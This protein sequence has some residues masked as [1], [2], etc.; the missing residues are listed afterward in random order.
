[1]GG[2]GKASVS[3]G[4][5]SCTSTLGTG[6]TSKWAIHFFILVIWS[7]WLFAGAMSSR[8]ASRSRWR[9]SK[10]CGILRALPSRIRLSS[11]TTWG[12]ASAGKVRAECFNVL[13]IVNENLFLSQWT[14]TSRRH[15]SMD[16]GCLE[17]RWHQIPEG[18]ERFRWKDPEEK[19]QTEVELN[20]FRIISSTRTCW[21]MEPLPTIGVAELVERS[22]S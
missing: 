15:L 12:L 14:C 9:S 19:W 17:L 4:L 13:P 11:V 3:S 20:N 8:S 6:T 21:L 22:A 16:G 7:F 18:T 10:R 5:D 2:T 1:M